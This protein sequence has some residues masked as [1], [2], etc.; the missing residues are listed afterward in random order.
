MNA[1]PVRTLADRT[2][3]L[4]GRLY[5]ST[6]LV[7]RWRAEETFDLALPILVTSTLRTLLRTT[8]FFIVSIALDDAAVAALEFGYQYYFLTL[9]VGMILSNGTISVVSRFIGAEDQRNADFTLKQ[10]LLLA[11]LFSVPISVG[12]WLYAPDLVDVLT[13]D[14]EVIRLGATYLQIVMLALVFRSWSLVALRGLQGAGDTL[15]PMLV[16]LVTLPTNIVLSAVLVFGVGPIPSFGIAG[17]AWGLAIAQTL[18]SLLFFAGAVS[19]RLAVQ[20]RLLDGRWWDWEIVGELVRVGYPLAGRRFVRYGVRFPFLFVL[21]TL[22]TPVVAAFAV[23]RRIIRLARLPSNGFGTATGT[24]V[25]QELGAGDE[26]EAEAFGRQITWISLLTQGGIA[27]VVMLAAPVLVRVFGVAE[28]G[29]AVLFVYVFGVT[30]LARSVTRILRASLQAA[31]D[32]TWPFYGTVVGSSLRL[33]FALLALPVGMVVLSVGNWEL[34]PGLGLGV[35]AV[36]AAILLDFY[37][38]LLVTAYRYRSGAWKLVARRS[39]VGQAGD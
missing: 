3:T 6:G 1:S 11:V 9:T 8:D 18:A 10:A 31:G 38:R 17:A 27:L 34:V 16:R 12:T 25:G 5:G 29:V 32:T 19:G 21:A 23:S 4:L 7:E 39:P 22:G 15:T 37:A 26:S 33:V 13:D 24:L 2:V 36:F 35:A 30:V 20:L 28:T 14:P